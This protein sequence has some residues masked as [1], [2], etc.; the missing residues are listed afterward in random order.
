MPTI[1]GH[2]VFAHSILDL[3]DDGFS[4]CLNAQ[5]LLHLHDVVA[6]S[7]SSNHA[8]SIHHLPQSIS[9][10]QQ[11]VD[12]SLSILLVDDGAIDGFDAWVELN[13]S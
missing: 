11:L 6:V 7:L 12:S 13:F 10:A 3:I 2:P 5:H 4:R 8:V 9:F 1:N